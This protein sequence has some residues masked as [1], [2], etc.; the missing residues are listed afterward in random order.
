VEEARKA[1]L[2]DVAAFEAAQKAD[3]GDPENPAFRKVR[4]MKDAVVTNDLDWTKNTGKK[5]DKDKR[6]PDGDDDPMDED[7]N[8]AF[9]RDM[10]GRPDEARLASHV[11]LHVPSLAPCCVLRRGSRRRW[12]ST[13]RC[14]L[15]TSASACSGRWAGTAAR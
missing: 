10:E 13:R 3:G 14:Q 2:E 4:E 9:K 5:R 1:V 6:K 12:R 15:R 8:D 11:V 7:E